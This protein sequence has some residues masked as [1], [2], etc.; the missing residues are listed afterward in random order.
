MNTIHKLVL[1]LVLGL[2]LASCSKNDSPSAAPKRD[3]AEQY[4]KDN[5]SIEEFL[6]THYMEIVNHPGFEDDQDVTFTEIPVGGTQVSVWD[7]TDDHRKLRTHTVEQNEI[8]YTIYYIN[9]R[10]GVGEKPTNV[11]GVY[12]SYKGTLLNGTVFDAA[13]NPQS[14]F[15]LESVIKG[16]SEIFPQFASG[17]Y[18]SNADGSTSYF[19]FGAGVMFLPSGLGY[20]NISQ[21]TIPAYSPLIFNIKLFEVERLDQDGDGIPSYL[22]DLDGDGYIRLFDEG[23]DNPDDTDGDGFPDYLDLDDDGDLVLTRTERIQYID[24]DT[25]EKFYYTF[26]AFEVAVDDP[27][28]PFDETQGIPSCGTT[29]DYTTPTRLRKH[30]DATCH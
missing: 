26:D 22:E 12:S 18:S 13:T 14:L 5:D 19:D 9:F 24:P 10:D 21:S 2:L 15:N 11:D 3:Y 28:T 17:T 6:Q 16:W 4:A 27:L 25:E 7:E 23:I 20:Y 29:P 30:R 8:T 1:T